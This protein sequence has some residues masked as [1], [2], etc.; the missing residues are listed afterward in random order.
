MLVLSRK[1]NET[2]KIGD[3]IEVTVVQISRGRVRL[4]IQAPREVPI[5]RS[6]LSTMSEANRKVDRE[7]VAR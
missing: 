2:V 7:L 6:E 3:D 4:A 1:L 5:L